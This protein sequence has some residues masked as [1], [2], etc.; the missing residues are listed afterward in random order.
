M[1]ERLPPSDPRE[2]LHR[3]RSCL[4]IARCRKPEIYHEDLCYQ[5]QQAAEKAIKAVFIARALPFPYIHDL[6]DLFLR[7]EKSGL[8]IP[9]AIK[10]ASRLTPFAVHTRYPGFEF[11]VSEEEYTEALV[12]AESVVYWAENIISV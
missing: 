4:A 6:S 10:T 11:P 8:A 5:A 3:A 12:L 2:W 1:P 9:D 7:L